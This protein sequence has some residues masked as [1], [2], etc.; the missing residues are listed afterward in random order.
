MVLELSRG[1]LQ[2]LEVALE[3][4]LEAS[5]N[6]TSTPLPVRCYLSLLVEEAVLQELGRLL[7]EDMEE[8]EA[9]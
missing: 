4:A 3:V 5:L 1:I 2:T 9:V 7:Q 8:E 6:A